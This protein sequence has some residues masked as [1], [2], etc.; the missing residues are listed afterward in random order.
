MDD[1]D[2]LCDMNDA[3]TSFRGIWSFEWN[4]LVAWLAGRELE[5]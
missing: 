3:T 1:G 4:W 5:H 2:D